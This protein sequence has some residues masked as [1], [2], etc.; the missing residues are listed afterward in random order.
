MQDKEELLNGKD[1]EDFLL[2]LEH[3]AEDFVAVRP[4]DYESIHVR[5]QMEKELLFTPSR[6]T[7]TCPFYLPPC[8]GQHHFPSDECGWYA[9]R[10]HVHNWSQVLI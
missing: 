5:L 1:A 9:R 3:V 10:S 7:G 8:L 4:A 6:Q 2:G